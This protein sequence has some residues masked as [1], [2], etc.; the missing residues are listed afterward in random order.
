LNFEREYLINKINHSIKTTKE[1]YKKV[2]GKEMDIINKCCLVLSREHADLLN[3]NIKWEND[4]MTIGMYIINGRP[5]ITVTVFESFSNNNLSPT[6]SME[7]Y[8]K[9]KK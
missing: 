8:K 1:N 5:I 7:I 9:I 6:I 4:D 2:S 3:N